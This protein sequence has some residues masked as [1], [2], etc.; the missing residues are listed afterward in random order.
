MRINSHPHSII[1]IMSIFVQRTMEVI[2]R[3]PFFIMISNLS[4]EPINLPKKM[5][6]ALG[7]EIPS[8][9]LTIPTEIIEKSPNKRI[10]QHTWCLTSPTIKKKDEHT[11]RDILK[12]KMRNMIFY[13]KIRRKKSTSTNI[14]RITE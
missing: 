2:P 3:Q 4:E 5:Y 13:R 9:I 10:P 14:E 11:K 7:E 12:V 1:K 8:K 6:V